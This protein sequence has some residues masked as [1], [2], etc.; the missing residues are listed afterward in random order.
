MPTMTYKGRQIRLT[1][2]MTEILEYATRYP[3][4]RSWHNIGHDEASKKAIE[5]LRAAGLV[6]IAEHSNQYRL[7]P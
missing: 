2:R 4:P 5:R 3:K 1:P 6:E 7:T